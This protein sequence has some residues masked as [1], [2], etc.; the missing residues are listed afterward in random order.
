MRLVWWSVASVLLPPSSSG[1]V[2]ATSARLSIDP[3]STLEAE[4]KRNPTLDAFRSLEAAYPA[5]Q[6][7]LQNPKS[8]DG[9]WILLSTIASSNGGRDL[10]AESA[11]T[12]AVNASGLIIDVSLKRL[13]VQEVDCK[14]GRIANE[15]RFELPFQRSAIVRVAGTFEPD[16]AFGRRA[17]VAFD[18]IELFIQDSSG[19]VF[20]LFRA[21]W[22]FPL[23]RRVKPSWSQ[24][25][26]SSS[27]LET[28]YIS[29]EAMSTPSAGDV[30]LGR[31]NKGSIFILERVTGPGALQPFPF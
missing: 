23:I 14:R 3:S 18:K 4:I 20:R 15:I 31:G 21:G 22:L 12:N 11:R 8:L 17:L 19:R 16:P 28:T 25:T 6:N 24:G 30:R 27:W 5:P 1:A 10:D 9:R 13:P 29:P 2:R 7:L 26:E